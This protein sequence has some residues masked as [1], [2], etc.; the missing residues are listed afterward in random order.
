MQ[1][2]L[3]A[4]DMEEQDQKKLASCLGVS[5]SECGFFLI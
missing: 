3:N 4:L 1:A 2:P 5:F